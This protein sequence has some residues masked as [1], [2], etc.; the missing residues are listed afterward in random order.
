MKYLETAVAFGKL[1][2]TKGK[3][4]SG[5]FRIAAAKPEKEVV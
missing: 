4:A 3:G 2:Q 1:V 5:S